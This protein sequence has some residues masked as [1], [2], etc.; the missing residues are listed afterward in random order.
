MPRVLILS[1]IFNPDNVSTAQLFGKIA[2]DLKILGHKIVVITTTPHFHR[3]ISMEQEQPLSLWCGKFI[4]K[5]LYKEIPVYH[6][7]MPDKQCHPLLRMMSWIGFHVISTFLA[8]LLRFKPHVVLAPSPP[9]LIGLNAYVLALLLRA[10]Y[11]YN[12]QEL[13]PDIAI[14]LGMIKSQFII[15]GLKRIESFIYNHSGAVTTITP[16]ITNKVT[17]RIKNPS[18]VKMIANFVDFNDMY[19]VERVNDFSKRYQLEDKFVI[20]YAGNVGI[21][22]NL[23]ILV[24]AMAFLPQLSSIQVLIIGDGGARKMLMEKIVAKGIQHVQMIDYQPISMMPQI[25]AASD[26]FYVG[27]TLGAHSDGIPSKIYRIMANTKALLAVAPESSDLAQMISENKTGWVLSSDSPCDL[28]EMIRSIQND[29]K[30]LLERGKNGH[31]Y[32][33]MSFERKMITRQYS[34]LVTSLS[35]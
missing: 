17:A 9:L 5:S 14:N 3:D 29:T 26:L 34:E 16:S 20:T 30:V 2:E 31:Q 27:Q 25:Y 8:L 12:V 1:L 23:D 24:E 11:I 4:Q 28:A 21:P 35:V 18:K 13:Y 19:S 15:K 10:K 33:K 32:V 6:I 22:Q 7:W